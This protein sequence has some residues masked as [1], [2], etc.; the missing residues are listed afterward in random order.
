M[1]RNRSNPPVDRVSWQDVW[2]WAREVEITW[3]C[4]V[5]FQQWPVRKEGFWGKWDVRCVARW[6]GVGGKVTREEAV[7]CVFPQNGAQS[8]P[9]AQL[10]LVLDLDVKLEELAR[11][12][13]QGASEQGRFGF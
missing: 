11:E 6:L 7:S 9:G 12:K 5:E 4:Y 13:K 1:S 10:K 8:L 3:H 2:N